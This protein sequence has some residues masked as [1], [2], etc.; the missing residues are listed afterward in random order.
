[1]SS[2]EVVISDIDNRYVTMKDF[3]GGWSAKLANKSLISR[4]DGIK[5]YEECIKFHRL[6]ESKE[7]YL[8]SLSESQHYKRATATYA[9]IL[10]RFVSDEKVYYDFDLGYH[11]SQVPDR[12]FVLSD[13]DYHNYD[14]HYG[15]LSTAR[16]LISRCEA[17]V[18][19]AQARSI[20]AIQSNLEEMQID[21]LDFYYDLR[22]MSDT[23]LFSIEQKV[24]LKNDLFDLGFKDA[25]TYLEGAEE[26]LNQSKPQFQDALHN[27][28]L[29]LEALIAKLQTDAGLVPQHKFSLDIN[30]LSRK[31]PNLLDQASKIAVQST[32][33]YLSMK[34]S[35]VY[36]KIDEKSLEEV[37]FGMDNAYGIVSHLLARYKE[38]KNGRA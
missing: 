27:A 16:K 21:L 30:E 32:Y 18:L 8:D 20:R 38:W 26:N 28:R 36:S 4:A 23:M 24:K 17:N 34:G 1:M 10:D 5:I 37:Q 6:I 2:A 12:F 7:K 13:S 33:S 14:S 31:E 29:T 15:I 22:L 9:K 19:T 3:I 25:V 35:H 11:G